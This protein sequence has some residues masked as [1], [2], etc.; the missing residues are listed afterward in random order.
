MEGKTVEL[1]GAS[2]LGHRPTFARDLLRGIT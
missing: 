1:E 2:S